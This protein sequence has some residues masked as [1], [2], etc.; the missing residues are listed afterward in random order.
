MTSLGRKL[1]NVRCMQILG[2]HRVHTKRQS[3]VDW[4]GAFPRTPRG[5][6][7]EGVESK[8]ED[9]DE[10]RSLDG[11]NSD[12][13]PCVK[14]YAEFNEK[15]KMPGDVTLYK[16]LIF[17]S[18]NVLWK[19][20]RRYLIQ[21]DFNYMYLKNGKIRVQARCM[22]DECDFY[23]FASKIRDYEAIQIKSFIPKHTC[24]TQYEN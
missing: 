4:L 24:G 17:P 19:A 12:E 20:L 23:I 1:T 6:E 16:G 21:K 9:N 10:F 2:V 7:G 5:E 14:K 8:Y 15:M 13:D 11:S 22:D 3:N 18:A